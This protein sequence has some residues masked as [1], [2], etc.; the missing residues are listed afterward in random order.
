MN[1]ETDQVAGGLAG[2]PDHDRLIII[3]SIKAGESSEAGEVCKLDFT[4]LDPATLELPDDPLGGFLPPNQAPP[5]GEGFVTYL[6]RPKTGVATGTRIDAHGTVIFD[7]SP[8]ETPAIFHTIDARPPTSSVDPLPATTSTPDFTVT[9]SG[10]DDLDGSGIASFDIFVSDNGG[11]FTVWQSR[12]PATS[13]VFTGQRDHAYAF[14]ATAVDNVG[15]REA[16]PL[17]ADAQIFVGDNRA[18]VAVDDLIDATDRIEC[19]AHLAAATV[20]D[21]SI[22][23]LRFDLGA[24]RQRLGRQ[25][26]ARVHRERHAIVTRVVNR[27]LNLQMDLRST[28]HLGDGIREQHLVRTLRVAAAGADAEDAGE[29]VKG[30]V[31]KSESP[32]VSATPGLRTPE[33]PDFSDER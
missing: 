10:S 32:K 16:A 15:H 11:P 30:V 29:K 25:L 27:L 1:F 26:A 18:P 24:E 21:R 31:R 3:D 13:A 2:A 22:H 7:G 33:P 4:S 14:Y 19:G 12:T 17:I 20:G 9:W 23:E 5:E 6:V 8:L 28:R